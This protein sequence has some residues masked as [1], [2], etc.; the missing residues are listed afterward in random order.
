MQEARLITYLRLQDRPIRHRITKV[1][2]TEGREKLNFVKREM[3]DQARGRPDE[4]QQVRQ[5]PSTTSGV[6]HTDDETDNVA[7]GMG[8][9]CRPP[10][11]P[12]GTSH[13]TETSTQGP[14]DP[15]DLRAPSVKPSLIVPY[16]VR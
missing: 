2:S 10:G 7:T 13:R 1:P 15:H 5:G 14:C 11:P 12:I 6:P 9:L 3:A 4:D 8:E 16:V